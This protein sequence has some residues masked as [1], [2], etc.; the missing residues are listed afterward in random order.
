MKLIKVY[1]EIVGNWMALPK[2]LAHCNLVALS[3][4]RKTGVPSDNGTSSNLTSH[5]DG[6]I[7]IDTT[8]ASRSKNKTT[9]EVWP[10]LRHSERSN[11]ESSGESKDNQNRGPGNGATDPFVWSANR[12]CQWNHLSH[13]HQDIWGERLD[14]ND[15]DNNNDKYLAQPG[16]M[17]EATDMVLPSFRIDHP[18]EASHL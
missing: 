13:T 7:L 5:H 17:T 3:G 11:K 15:N 16:A 4:L 6:W 9:Q 18:Q 10:P 8:L 12:N 2:S 14:K 1:L